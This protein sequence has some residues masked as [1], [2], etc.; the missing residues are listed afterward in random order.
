MGKDGEVYK[1]GVWDWFIHTTKFKIGN[2]EGPTVYHRE[3]YSVFYKNLNEKRIW[4]IIGICVY[5][6]ES[7]C[8]TSETNTTLIQ[9]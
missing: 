1:L 6:T 5:I 4:K 2:Q 8:Y 3:H 9:L 7:F